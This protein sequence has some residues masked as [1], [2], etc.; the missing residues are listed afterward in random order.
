M[1]LFKTCIVVLLLNIQADTN[2]PCFILT[3]TWN[4]HKIRS[5]ICL[6]VANRDIGRGHP[7]KAQSILPQE[8][9]GG[10]DERKV[11][12]QTRWEERK[13]LSLS[14][15]ISACQ[16]LEVG[17]ESCLVDFS[18]S[19]GVCLWNTRQLSTLRKRSEQARETE[20]AILR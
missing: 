5:T 16:A 4:G 12:G 9:G 14:K 8:G 10:R 19:P 20:D 7:R 18:Q 11:S 17:W 3:F 1:G 6:T 13:G 15:L 2:E